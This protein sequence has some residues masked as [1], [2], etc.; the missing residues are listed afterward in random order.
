M[1]L[2]EDWCPENSEGH[3]GGM[4][5]LKMALAKSINTVSAK[6]MHRVGPHQVIDLVKKL[7]VDTKKHPRST[8]HRP[9]H[10]RPQP[11]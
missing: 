2:Q 11:L 10:G 6:L 8:V 4:V 1:G 5:S 7:G 9:G 3:Y